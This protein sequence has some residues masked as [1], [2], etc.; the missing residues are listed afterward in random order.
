M[1]WLFVHESR[2]HCI[3]AVHQLVCTDFSQSHWCAFKILV[4]G[5]TCKVKSALQSM[6]SSA[7]T[8]KP[9]EWAGANLRLTYHKPKT[10]ISVSGAGECSQDKWK[11]WWILRH[12][13]KWMCEQL[14]NCEGSFMDSDMLMATL[15][16]TSAR[17][18]LRRI[19]PVLDFLTPVSCNC[20]NSRG[21]EA[22]FKHPQ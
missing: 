5:F 4:V 12:T 15:Y 22:S 6:S 9:L 21:E 17:N 2:N 19:L 1:L 3:W 20:P 18:V 16:W 7:F 13:F 10:V 14:P 8:F 11:T